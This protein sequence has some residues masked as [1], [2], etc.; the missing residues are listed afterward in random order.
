MANNKLE[1]NKLNIAQVISVYNKSLRHDFPANERRPLPLIIKG[2]L[3]G[4]YECLGAFYKGRLIGYA[5][6]LKH[7]NDY[8]W[9]YLAVFERYRCKGAGAR[10][11]KAVKEY[12]KTAD[13]VIGEVE[14]PEL[15]GPDEDN[16][17][18]ARR[19]NFYLR[20]GCIDT[21]VRAV[22]FGAHFII[23]QISGRKMSDTEV[24]KLYRTHYRVSLPKRIYD[25]NIKTYEA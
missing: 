5:F 14:N 2:M 21:G 6:F 22:T 18:M 4:T 19:L 16:D 10:I 11:I 17:M 12:Y 23:I 24:A 25:G 8:L 15:A 9:D 7:G 13:S 3:F 1:I 20:N